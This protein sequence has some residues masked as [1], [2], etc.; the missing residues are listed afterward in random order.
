MAPAAPRTGDAV[1]ASV[2]RVNAE[3]FTLTYGAI[4]RQLLTDLEEVDEVNKQL[5]QMGYNIGVRLIDEFLAKS[6]IS[7]CVD[8]K[9]TAEVIAKVGFK[10]F[11]GVTATVTNWDAEGTSCSLVL[12]ENPLVDFVELPDTCQG[13]YYCN[14][15]SGV[16]RGALEMVSMKTEVTW[17]RDILH[18]D[19]ACELR[20]KLVKQIPEEYPYKDDD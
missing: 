14:I 1:F 7:R 8:F 17:V 15:L 2:E 12:E 20:V 10:I 11:L 5:D 13:L 4:V 19:D 6:N 3:L 16:I 18:G 9:E